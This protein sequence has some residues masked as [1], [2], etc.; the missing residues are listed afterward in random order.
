MI[1]SALRRAF[2]VGTRFRVAAV[3]A[4][5]LGASGPAAATLFSHDGQNLAAELKSAQREGRRLA[6]YFELPDCSGCREM[7]QHVFSER[8][9]ERNF[10]RQ[11]RTVRIDLAATGDI[12]DT[13]G[14]R[15]TPEALAQRL[16]IAGTPAFAF[17]ERDGALAYRHV[18]A[19]PAP[20]DFIRLGR[21][22][23][24]A[25]YENQPFAEYRQRNGGALHAEASPL[26]Q[27]RHDF[28]LHDQHGRLRH[29]ADF[30]GKS[31]ALAVGYTQCPDVCPT[32]LAELQA[33]VDA[34]GADARHVQVLF[35]TLDPQRDTQK[36]LGPYVTAFRADFLALRGDAAQ[37]ADFIRRFAL[38]AE[39]QP[40]AS[41]G[42]TLDHTVGI[43]LFDRRGR[44]RGVSP[45]GQPHNLLADD[46]KT[47]AAESRKPPTTTHLSQR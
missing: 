37:T 24:S 40:S 5:L 2:S 11:F 4:L 46:L 22:V 3:A 30:R 27:Q 44:L 23:A 26:A 12:F 38:V 7:K 15:R 13:D 18:G 47:L 9:A 21:F 17:F 35:A 25:A 32:T 10:G 16:R 8:R 29:L 14:K 31:V 28:S 6:V 33:A 39:R 34:L 1:F 42:Y 36:I 41:Q 43:F 45:Y 19:L 20:A